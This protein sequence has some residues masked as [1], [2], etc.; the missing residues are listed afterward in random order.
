MIYCKKIRVEG[1]EKN[2]SKNFVIIHPQLFS[3]PFNIL[4]NRCDNITTLAEGKIA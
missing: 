1:V 4:T 3:K 2:P